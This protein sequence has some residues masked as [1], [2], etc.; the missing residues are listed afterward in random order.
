MEKKINM[1]IMYIFKK[2]MFMQINLYGYYYYIFDFIVCV[3]LY[4]KFDSW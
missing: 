3:D 2:I 1:Y 4:I